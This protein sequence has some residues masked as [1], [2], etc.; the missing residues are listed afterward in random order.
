MGGRVIAWVCGGFEDGEGFA[1]GLVGWWE[2]G[3]FEFEAGDHAVEP[4][5]IGLN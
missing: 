3:W 5:F 1:V 4:I 2:G